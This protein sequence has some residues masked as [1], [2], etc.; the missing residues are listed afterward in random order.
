MLTIYREKEIIHKL[1]NWNQIV[2][3]SQV[4][5]YIR[6]KYNLSSSVTKVMVKKD[7]CYLATK[8]SVIAFIM[9]IYLSIEHKGKRKT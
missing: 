3:N 7:D 5:Y 8:D 6:D 2:K 9:D 4:D 1:Q